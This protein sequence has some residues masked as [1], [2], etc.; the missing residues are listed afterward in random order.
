MI[1]RLQKPK[2]QI[3]ILFTV[4]KQV[5]QAENAFNYKKTAW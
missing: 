2:L 3:K 4:E 5:K 1:I